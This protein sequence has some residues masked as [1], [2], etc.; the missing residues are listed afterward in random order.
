MPAQQPALT[1][2]QGRRYPTLHKL[3]L[4]NMNKGRGP[5]AYL[6]GAMA[7]ADRC[8]SGEGLAQLA[9]SA[10][11][12]RQ[13]REVA[14]WWQTPWPGRPPLPAALLA[15]GEPAPEYDLSITVTCLRSINSTNS[16]CIV[17]GLCGTLPYPTC[18][19]SSSLQAVSAACHC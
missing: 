9:H 7:S 18:S 14:A 8:C 2:L 12:A 17:Q 4:R 3:M 1:T 5:G 15:P 13:R 16:Q 11:C 6:S 10:R 19:A